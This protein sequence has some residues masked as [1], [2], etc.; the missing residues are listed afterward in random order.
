MKDDTLAHYGVLGMKWGVRRYQNK[1]GSL[2][3]AGKNRYRKAGE[4]KQ[5]EVKKSER[6]EKPE[7][8]KK[9]KKSP[10]QLASE[11]QKKEDAMNRGTLT[12][13]QIKQRIERLKLEKELRELT[14]SEISAGQKFVEDILKEVGKKTFQTALTGGALYM[15]KAA[16]S[17][18]FDRKELAQA[19][20]SGGKGGDTGG[21]KKK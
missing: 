15:T 21:G 18:E 6:L 3:T 19:V 10:E 7:K 17:R 4:Q 20:F 1:D 8:P 5:G 14:K 12:N 9:P 11:R 13:E 2:T 16:I